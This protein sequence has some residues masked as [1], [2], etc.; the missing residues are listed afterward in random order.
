MD[1]W[2]FLPDDVAGD[3]ATLAEIPS[4]KI[5]ALRTLM[6]SGEYRPRTKSFVKV[7]SLLSVSD[8]T[9]AKLCTFI[10]YVQRQRETN[11]ETGL[12]VVEELARFLTTA[13]KEKELADD[14]GRLLAYVKENSQ[15]LARLFS[16]LPGYVHAEKVRDLEEGPVP[17]LRGFRAYCDLRP[18]F[19]AGANEIL[20][21]FPVITLSLSTHTADTDTTRE[22]LI[23]LTEADLVDFRNQFNRL[24]KK[25][26]KL[27]SRCLE[28]PSPTRGESA[29]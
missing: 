2:L 24:E 7:A 19:D 23:Q 16:E 8:E 1:H 10:D 25:L 28:L 4:A 3:L 12:A 18:V 17:H 13:A 15:S 27:K 9:A 26:A 20:S 6:D 29:K 11:N 22:V 21:M 14:A 5:D